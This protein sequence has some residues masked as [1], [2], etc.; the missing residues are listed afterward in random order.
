MNS[1]RFNR[2]SCICLPPGTLPGSIA[3][4][5]SLR[6]GISVRLMTARGSKTRIR[7]FRVYVSCFRQLRT[8]HRICSGPL[9]ASSGREQVQQTRAAIRSYS[10]ISSARSKS[11]VEMSKP[12]AFAVR[13]LSTNS[14]FV[15]RSIGIL[16]G[17]S[18]RSTLPLMT[19]TCR[20][21]SNRFGP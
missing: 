10:I 4:W 18:P 5:S 20:Y 15:G 7:R 19:P 12:M 21:R 6:C 13:R 3:D 8:S 16:A 11:A 14:N 17:F 1:R 2:L 9:C